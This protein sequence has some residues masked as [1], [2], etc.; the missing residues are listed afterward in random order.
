MLELEFIPHNSSW[1]HEEK[2]KTNIFV[3]VHL[4]LGTSRIAEPY[5]TFVGSE[6][7]KGLKIPSMKLGHKLQRGNDKSNIPADANFI[8]QEWRCGNK[9]GPKGCQLI[10]NEEARH[11]GKDVQRRPVV[12][13]K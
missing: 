6:A 7:P 4:Y 10:R 13:V 11:Y 12:G 9:G 5:S 1:E 2:G 8:C 3:L